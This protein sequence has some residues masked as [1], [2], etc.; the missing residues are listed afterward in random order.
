LYSSQIKVLVDAAV[1]LEHGN[2]IKCDF[3]PGS[4]ER[5]IDLD[6]EEYLQQVI[7]G[8]LRYQ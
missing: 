5:S 4:L 2:G 8:I 3:K 1:H 7:F 6:K